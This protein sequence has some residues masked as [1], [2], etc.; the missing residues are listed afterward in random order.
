MN[1]HTIGILSIGSGV[2]QSVVTSCRQSALPLHLV[3]LGTNPM[4]YGMY[5]CHDAAMIPSFYAPDYPDVLLET[6]RRMGIGLLIPGHDDEAHL[7][8]KLSGRFEA[9]GVKVICAGEALLSLCRDKERMSEELNK[10]ANVFVRGFARDDFLVA[11]GR[12]EVELPV[13]AK[14]RSGFASRGVE[15]INTP[16]DFIKIKDTHIIQELAIPHE[17]DPNHRYC[18]E[19]LRKGINPQVSEI[20]I[21]VVIGKD[22][23]ELGRMASYNKLNNGVPIEILPYEDPEV[24]KVVDRLMPAFMDLGL[25]GPF[26]LQGRMTN[27]GLK[28]FELNARFTGITGLRALMGFNEVDACIRSWMRDETPSLRIN[29]RKAG[30]R[31]TLDRTVDRQRNEDIENSINTLNPER[32]SKTKTILITGASGSVGRRVAVALAKDP[33]YEVI[34]L[35]RDKEKTK[36]L[37]GIGNFDCLDWE[38][39]ENGALTIGNVDTLIHLA[40][41]RPHHTPSEIANSL[42]LATELFTRAT[43]GGVH[44]IIFASSQAVY[45]TNSPTP[46][47]ETLAPHPQTPYAFHKFSAEQQLAA[48]RHIF[49]ELRYCSLRLGGLTGPD[50]EIAETEVIAKLTNRALQGEKLTIQGGEQPINR[51]DVQ[52]AADGIIALLTID[53]RHWPQVVNLGS[54]EQVSLRVILGIISDQVK[55]KTGQNVKISWKEGGSGPVFQLDSRIFQKLTQ[56]KPRYSLQMSIDSIATQYAIDYFPALS[57]EINKA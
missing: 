17:N 25:R 2:G 57:A 53:S 18:L 47:D 35:D 43:K 33:D 29:Q 52:D 19:Q 36:R 15:I 11:F 48:L 38:D 12:G 3:G 24:W 14:P 41:A 27:R 54:D 40:S 56:W 20:S 21:Q 34:T 5:D 4:A 31:Q 23:T 45:G 44:E 39:L 16:D 42:S 37:L 32:L 9:E 1:K 49:P 50:P 55:K 28:L 13:I 46:W 22:G 7:L 6:C 30:I 8:A 10:I 51:L 26:N